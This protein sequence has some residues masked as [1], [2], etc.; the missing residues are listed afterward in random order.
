VKL[1]DWA[2]PVG[3]VIL[4]AGM[5]LAYLKGYSHGVQG[6]F[7]ELREQGFTLVDASGNVLPWKNK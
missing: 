6:S 2:V 3:L 1:P 5:F 4:V 7:D